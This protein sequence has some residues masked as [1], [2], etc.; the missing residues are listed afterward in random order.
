MED[1]SKYLQTRLNSGQTADDYCISEV[2]IEY[3]CR[4]TDDVTIFTALKLS[5]LWIK[6]NYEGYR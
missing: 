1:I 2:D 3:F 6:Q 4:L 5:L